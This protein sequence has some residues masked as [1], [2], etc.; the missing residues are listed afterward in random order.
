MLGLDKNPTGWNTLTQEW[1]SQE[2]EETQG[3]SM[4]A[5]KIGSFSILGAF[6]FLYFK[7]PSVLFWC[8]L[9]CTNPNSLSVTV[10]HRVKK[11]LA[12]CM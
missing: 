9:S 10:I 3:S 12:Q 11:L 2:H 5:L 7:I 4:G 8:E 6:L 1:R